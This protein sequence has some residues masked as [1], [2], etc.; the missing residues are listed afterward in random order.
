M[1]IDQKYMFG[2]IPIE[3]HG[4]MGF[5]R[6]AV[7]KKDLFKVAVKFI[8]PE[9]L[10]K[11]PASRLAFERE[12]SVISKLNHTNIVK[13]LDHGY[14]NDS[15]SYF[16][17]MPW[18]DRNLSDL[19]SEKKFDGWDDYWYRVGRF[20]LNA[21]YHTHLN[22]VAHRDLKP[23][24][25]L[26]DDAGMPVV[27]DFGIAKFKLDGEKGETQ[28][29][30][31]SEPY[32]PAE[33]EPA[34]RC[35]SRDVYSF[36][37]VAIS[38]LVNRK[39]SSYEDLYGAW[40]EI[41]VAS[42][43]RSILS[44]CIEPDWRDRYPTCIDLHDEFILLSKE[45]KNKVYTIRVSKI[46]IK[47]KSELSDYGLCDISG[48]EDYVC[49]LLGRGASI[50]RHP[51]FGPEHIT[52]Y[53]DEFTFHGKIDDNDAE[54]ICILS[55]K[56]VSPDYAEIVRSE[57]YSCPFKFSI[58]SIKG[59]V[60]ASTLL[61]YLSE[62]TSGSFPGESE[63]SLYSKWSAILFLKDQMIRR[64][65][66]DVRYS[67]ATY[68]YGRI[69]VLVKGDIPDAVEGQSYY[70]ED[71]ESRFEVEV[72]RAS[73]GS[74]VVSLL[75]GELEKF[76]NR[77]VLKFDI[78][79][80]S[81]SMQRQENALSSFV[82]RQIVN[83]RIGDILQN[84]LECSV[85]KDF[86]VSPIDSFDESKKQSHVK[87][88]NSK[89]IFLLVGPPG[90]GKTFFISD[91]IS[92][93]IKNNPNIKILVVA[94]THNAVDNAIE[95]FSGCSLKGAIIR[96]G[97]LKEGKIS[98]HAK[99]YLLERVAKSWASDVSKRSLSS[100]TNV[101]TKWGL[102]ANI[103]DSVLL[104]EQIRSMSQEKGIICG[105]IRS[106][107]IKVNELDGRVDSRGDQDG[108]K[109]IANIMSETDEMR[110]LLRLK[111]SALADL[112]FQIEDKMRL[113]SK[114]GEDGQ[115]IHQFDEREFLSW[116]KDVFSHENGS[117][118]AELISLVNDWVLRLKGSRDLY[119][120]VISEASVVAGT[121]IGF[122]M[123]RAALNE[124]YDLV[125]IDEA[126]KVTPTE[127]LVPMARAKKVILVGDSN[128]L[129]PFI[130][131]ELLDED[132]LSENNLV[133][134]DVKKTLFSYLEET[135]P[136]GS[137]ASLWIQ[138]RM[139]KEISNLVSEVFYEGKLEPSKERAS[140]KRIGLIGKPVVFVDYSKSRPE[141]EIKVGKGLINN[142]EV[143]LIVRDLKSLQSEVGEKNIDV[144]IIAAYS[145]Q[146][147][148]I[149]SRVEKIYQSLPNLRVSVETVHSYQGR[150]ADVVFVSFVRS[151]VKNN[152]G[153]L[154]QRSIVNVAVSRAREQLRMYCSADTFV[155]ANV[156]NAVSE[157]F[158]YVG[159][160]D[161]CEVL[162]AS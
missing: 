60:S 89:E 81:A 161:Q 155:R 70:I 156:P 127:L 129:P 68:Q 84:P 123:N 109:T 47:V 154:W 61:D 57:S 39:L 16:F 38:C 23:E 112:D 105:D 91:I 33:I 51:T 50:N 126:S 62:K 29:F 130:E 35:Q 115:E 26:I 138:Y 125:I 59:S 17:E 76:P 9:V 21:L 64:L 18:Y 121:C 107:R 102:D 46:S 10:F 96:I 159:R 66:P 22:D 53:A 104:S 97:S 144:A 106:I 83:P 5:V 6:Q 152:I 117:V 20:V 28:K 30:F 128:Q 67:E 32:T 122:S 92:E 108:S 75:K 41:D 71:E 69:K 14:D 85:G 147:H 157:I 139:R 56:R 110:E 100:L 114:H 36:G 73:S 151:N 15:S 136:E 99:Q 87:L 24:N 37:V 101:V 52:F 4:G 65:C 113:L 137:K 135:L 118:S 133:L 145:A 72:E 63:R 74:L 44:K 148:I 141:S 150:E 25:I 88:L 116:R 140:A 158:L 34:E 40:M 142:V 93:E 2:S 12:I 143:D 79:A 134:D 77:G 103:V 111:Q 7:R 119:P 19:F 3:K 86:S 31:G 131:N 94:Q 27:A 146:R 45:P 149:A 49:D 162:N 13:M 1:E 78:K 98:E 160:S 153:F 95:A 42:P 11:Q 80:H 58:S 55:V 8:T 90:S 82:S 54:S 43:V 132:L 48:A 120:A 124:E